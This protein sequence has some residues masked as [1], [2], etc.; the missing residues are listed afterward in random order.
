MKII[1]YSPH[2]HL[3]LMGPTGY[4]THMREM[5]AAFRNEGCEVL[6][7]IMGGTDSPPN[8]QPD[9]NQKK[10][11][12]FL[13]K[14][15]GKRIWRTLKDLNLLRFDY[16]TASK[17]LEEV[18]ENFHPDCIYERCNYLQLSG[19]KVAERYN[20]THIMEMNSPYIEE[21]NNLGKGDSYLKK[22][23][24]RVEKEQLMNTNLPLV[25]VGPL[26]DHFQQQYAVDKDKFLVT[27]NAFKNDKIRLDYQNQQT[28]IKKY[29][30]EDKTVIGFVGSIF[31]WHGLDKLIKAFDELDQPDTKLLIVGY[32]EYMAN[33]IRLTK[34]LG[35]EEEVIFTGRVPKNEVFDYIEIMDICTAPAAAWY[36][37]PVKIFEY[38]AMGKPILGPDTAAVREVM[39][40]G[41]DGVLIAPTVEAAQNGI[42]ELLENPERAQAMAHHFQQKVLQEYTWEK[43]VKKVLNALQNS[44][45]DEAINA[46]GGKAE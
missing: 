29:A 36:Q 33:L 43:N 19:I 17:H 20:I 22:Y 15:T 45:K 24:R 28:I 34:S 38:G 35:R 13:K 39:E 11:K 40:P 8:E 25:V 41:K 2:P 16:F 4:G 5:I 30:L 23:A 9:H 6:P 37:S 1:Y 42:L 44:V 10:I 31:E 3:N 18:V 7:V 46:S 26:R 12:D 32:G 14:I 27:H 21:T